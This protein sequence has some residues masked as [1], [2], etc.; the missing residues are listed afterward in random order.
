MCFVGSMLACPHDN[1]RSGPT[2]RSSTPNQ[3]AELVCY[4]TGRTNTGVSAT[5]DAADARQP[6]DRA[7]TAGAERRRNSRLD[8]D[9][10]QATRGTPQGWIVAKSR[11]QSSAAFL[12]AAGAAARL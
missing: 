3:I 9:R 11:P 4:G 2:D 5:T 1:A 6:S 12:W 7:R 10:G 8:G